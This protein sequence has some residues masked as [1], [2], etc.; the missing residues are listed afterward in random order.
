M[1]RHPSGTKVISAQQYLISLISNMQR[2]AETPVF[3][4]VR[5]FVGEEISAFKLAHK[6]RLSHG[7]S[8]HEGRSHR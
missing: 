8:G 7:L 4:L 3:K 2:A 5:T 6:R 1:R